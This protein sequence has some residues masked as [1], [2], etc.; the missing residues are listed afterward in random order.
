MRRRRFALRLSSAE[1]SACSRSCNCFGSVGARRRAKVSLQL[2]ALSSQLSGM[3]FLANLLTYWWL[4]R[5]V[6]AN[7]VTVVGMEMVKPTPECQD[8][9]R[10]PN[11]LGASTKDRD[12]LTGRT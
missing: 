2:E 4:T 8:R 12:T 10:N 7:W 6:R 5:H 9:C 1:C 11:F 3:P